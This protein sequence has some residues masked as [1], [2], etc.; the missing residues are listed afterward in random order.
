MTDIDRLRLNSE[1]IP[2]HIRD[3][4]GGRKTK[5]F[6]MGPIDLG[7]ILGAIGLGGSASN[8][9]ILLHYYL[10]LNRGG[11][12]DVSMKRLARDIDCS[13]DTVVRAIH[14][15]ESAGLVSVERR[16]GRRPRITIV[17]VVEDHENRP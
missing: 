8:V 11:A 5:P 7:W 10:G 14:A 9:G 15:L 12:V 17:E 6:I 4:R 16:P 13:R 2:S 3:K 1:A